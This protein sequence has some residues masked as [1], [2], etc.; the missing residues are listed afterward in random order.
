MAQNKYDDT[1][2]SWVP[3]KIKCSR[4]KLDKNDIDRLLNPDDDEND[5]DEEHS[6]C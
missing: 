4:R 2:A 3:K 5:D 6:R 1:F